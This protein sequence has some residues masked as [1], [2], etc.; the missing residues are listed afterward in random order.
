MKIAMVSTRATVRVAALSA[1]LS[2]LGHEVSLYTRW[3]TP[4]VAEEVEAPEGYTQVN[5]PAGPPEPVSEQAAQTVMGAFAQYLDRAW[6]SE[7]PDVTHAHGWLSGVASQL[8]A[9]HIGLPS[10][11][12][13]HGLRLVPEERVQ[14]GAMVAKAADWVAATCTDEVVEL[15]RRG[16]PRNGISVVPVGIDAKTFT[17]DGVRAAKGAD[18]RILSIGRL[19][20]D[21]GFDT[22]VRAIT[23][24]PEAELVV[25]GGPET[26]DLDADQEAGRLRHLAEELGVTRRVHLIGSVAAE[27]LPPLVRSADV[28]ACSPVQEPSGTAALAAMACGVPV[29]ASAVGALNDIVVDDVTGRLV[30]QINPAGFAEAINMLLRDS[31][32]RR[33]F[34]AAGRDRASARYS[35][36][37]VAEDMLRVYERFAPPRDPRLTTS[38]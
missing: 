22:L 21:K 16:R 6:S 13:F 10:V 29:V 24:I 3:T 9:R 34:G 23:M 11:L 4:D 27:E 19:V 1:A 17:P 20:P 35:W 8:A 37:R 12:T 31:F 33:S 14:L 26:H 25:I 5:V 32:L 18:N 15:T 30:A 2:R 28:V 38:A 36:D 7:P